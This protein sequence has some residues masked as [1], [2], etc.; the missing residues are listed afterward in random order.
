[1]AQNYCK[2]CDLVL[3]SEV[4]FCPECGGTVEKYKN[5][6]GARGH[7]LGPISSDF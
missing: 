3:D 2:K 7:F 4:K 5:K 1:M 6:K